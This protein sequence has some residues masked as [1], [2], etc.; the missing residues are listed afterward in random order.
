MAAIKTSSKSRQIKEHVLNQVATGLLRHGDCLPT[1]ME[2][3]RSLGVGRHSVRQALAELSD[4]GMVERKKKRGTMVTLATPASVREDAKADYALIIPEVHSGVYPSL[5]KGFADGALS[6]QQRSLVCE[7]G[8]DIYRQGDTILRLIQNNVAGVALVPAQEPMPD[9][10]VQALRSRGIPLVFCHRKTTTLS[11]PLI[12]WSWEEVGRLAA[13]TLAE[14]GHRRIAFVD[15][16]K[17]I[18][19]EGYV[20][21][22]RKELTRRE[23]PF[24]AE[25]EFYGE[26]ILTDAELQ[27]AEEVVARV[28]N[29]AERPTAIFCGD[30]YMSE[31][32]FLAAMKAGIRVP[33]D[34]AIIGFGSTYR[35]G[36]VRK[37][38]AAIAVDEIEVG[39]QAARIL[40]EISDGRRSADDN[41]EVVLPLT[42]LRGDSL[43]PPPS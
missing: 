40:A 36:P 13:T 18:A 24:T 10:Q 6:S 20:A 8:I 14:L 32:L 22:F 16:A 37:G 7:A 33:Q 35:D 28:L 4:A 5:I 3:A 21:G 19:T 15:N 12:K 23:I 43:G 42:I 38:L 26:H 11:A 1:E 30:D 41:Q 34:L 27:Y 39:R 31:R 2:L 17:S 9:H 29:Q 25:C